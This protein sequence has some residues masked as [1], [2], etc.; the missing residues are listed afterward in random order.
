[1]KSPLLML[2]ALALHAQ[3]PKRIVLSV[4]SDCVSMGRISAHLNEPIERR[5]RSAESRLEAELTGQLAADPQVSACLLYPDSPT[6][7]TG[8]SC[9][10]VTIPHYREITCVRPVDPAT[11][12]DY[13]A[14]YDS[15]YRDGEYAYLRHATSCSVTNKS[16]TTA[17]PSLF[18]QI[19]FRLAKPRLGFVTGIGT[20]LTPRGRAYHGFADVDPSVSKGTIEV[21]D[22]FKADDSVLPT[23]TSENIPKGITVSV[24]DEL[25]AARNYEKLVLNKAHINIAVRF[26]TI[27]ITIGGDRNIPESRRRTDLDNWQ[28]GVGDLLENNHFRELTSDEL[29]QTPFSST[30][31]IREFLLSNGPFATKQ[32]LGATLGPHVLFLIDDHFEGCGRAAGVLVAEPQKG[33]ASDYGGLMVYAI[34]FGYCGNSRAS[35]EYLQQI[36]EKSTRYVQT[37]VRQR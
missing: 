3:E 27:K 30:D 8:F 17:S 11:V 15:E 26:R 36:I 5:C 37:Q 1:M 13:I 10:D 25:E 9:V 34:A 20:G 33:I 21:F 23:E 32:T 2:L 24:D 7:L 12:S 29:G 16:A 19:L 31:D 14:H 28:S 4:L 35:G 18:P 6:S 22:M